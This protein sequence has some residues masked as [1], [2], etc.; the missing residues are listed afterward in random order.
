MYA[1]EIG[2]S[3]LPLTLIANGRCQ[4]DPEVG[5]ASISQPSAAKC[6]ATTIFYQKVKDPSKLYHNVIY[7][8]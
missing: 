5:A 1:F 3:L 8:P 4:K 6:Q 2:C 7:P